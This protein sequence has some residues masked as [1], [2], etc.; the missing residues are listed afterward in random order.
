MNVRFACVLCKKV[1]IRSGI[2]SYE[3]TVSRKMTHF[4]ADDSETTPDKHRQTTE[5]ECWETNRTS[6]YEE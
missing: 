4:Q 6:A 2:Y 5:N 1:R 3:S